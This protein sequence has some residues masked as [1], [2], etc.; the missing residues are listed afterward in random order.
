[1]NEKI[2]KQELAKLKYT[3]PSAFKDFTLQDVQAMSVLWLNDFKNDDP[4]IFKQAIDRLRAK[5][6]YCPS[7]AEIKSEITK[8]EVPTLQ[9][10]AEE[11]FEKV[12][13]AIRKFGSYRT[14]EL[15]NSLEPYTREITRRI[16]ISR[17][18]MAEDITWIKKEFIEEFNNSLLRS[19]EILQQ[20]ESALTDCE[21][22]E[23]EKLLATTEKIFK[24]IGSGLNESW[25]SVNDI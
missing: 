15:M 9:L 6:K 17:I 13:N 11:E 24:R 7:I 19:K 25:R 8:I 3:Y 22:K 21:K 18:C 4:E 23:K 2:I 20:N 10:N 12:R 16:G 1:M 5:S 14:T